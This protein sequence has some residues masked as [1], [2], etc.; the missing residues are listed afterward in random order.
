[1]FAYK[2]PITAPHEID[3]DKSNG[4]LGA[5][6]INKKTGGIG[7]LRS[8][9]T[10]NET[11]KI[12][13]LIPRS[14]RHRCVGVSKSKISSLP[15]HVHTEDI[16]VVNFYVSVNGEET[17]FFTGEVSKIDAD[18]DDNGNGYFF[19]NPEK[20]KPAQ[21][22][23]ANAG[24]V[25]ALDTQQPHAVVCQNKAQRCVVQVYFDLPLTEV[26]SGFQ[27]THL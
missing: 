17:T 3:F 7:V 10:R 5:H 24:D 2:L 1:M 20:L 23:I 25:W 11:A 15:V 9:A 27:C 13:R 6:V 22:F 19:V 18:T 4:F 16:C 21:S 8:K 14:L 26:I 12:L